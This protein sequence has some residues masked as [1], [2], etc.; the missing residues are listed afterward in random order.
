MSSYFRKYSKIAHILEFFFTNF[1]LNDFIAV[2]I[3]K[4]EKYENIKY[5]RK[6]ICNLET[7]LPSNAI[8]VKESSVCLFIDLFK[9]S[10]QLYCCMSGVIRAGH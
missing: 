7:F 10:W 1:T 2:N 3:E 6:H 9:N 4:I 5:I 8:A